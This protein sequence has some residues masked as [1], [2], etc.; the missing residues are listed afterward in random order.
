MSDQKT[1]RINAQS[2]KTELNSYKDKSYKCLFEYLWNSFDAG[3]TEIKF[4]YNIPTEGIGYVSNVKI[5]DNGKGWDFGV[6]SNTETFLASSKSEQNTNMKTLPKGKFGRGRYVFIW[7]A[8]KIEIKSGNSKIILHHSTKIEKEQIEKTINGTEIDFIGVYPKF[9]D[10]L[11]FE[12]KLHNELL[13][14]FGWYLAE[15]E[16]Y[17]ISINNV[18]LNFNDNIKSTKNYTKTDFPDKIKSQLNDD[19][20]AQIILWDNKPSEFSKFYFLNTKNV[21]IFKQ[22]TGL[23]KQGDDFWHSVYISSNIF[24]NLNG[25]DEDLETTQQSLH[26]GDKKIKKL[27]RQIISFLKTELSLLRKPYLIEQSEDL[28]DELKDDNI[29]PELTEFGIYDEKS[30]FD[31]IKTIYTITPSLFTGKG[32]SEKKFICATFAGL[33]STQDDDLIKIILEQLQELSEE[34]KKDLLDILNRSSLSNIVKT[35]KEIDHRL[36]VLEKLKILISEHEKETLEVK[37]LQ[38]IL[39]VNFWV[40]G[41]QFRLFSTTEGALKN[42]LYKYAKEIL[43]IDNPELTTQPNGEVD[44]FLTKT[45]VVGNVQKNIVVELK[46][47]SKKLTESK[48]YLQINNYRKSI[49]KQA[50]CN[51]EN[52]YWEFYLIGKNYD[53]GIAQLIENAKQHGEKEKG[54][55]F[56]LNGKVKIYVRKWSDILEVEWGTKMKY[57][58]EKLEIQAKNQE[59]TKPQEI[60]SEIIEKS[61]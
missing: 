56:N 25:L 15:N 54:L 58:K 31:L 30:Y 22:N 27:K 9:S 8:D 38:K 61:T 44:L 45:E 5:I 52:Q 47:A 43:E 13:L 20:N 41:E 12:E 39:D 46:R 7:I 2:I 51:G 24:K 16:K 34:E 48:D 1:L 57:L 3:A 28:L 19:F 50:L 37:H 23:N 49:L 59:Y 40:F 6:N 29:I 42:V 36:D 55:A 35:I 21:E 53:E 33:L 17:S 26:F 18:K 4:N 32:K 60:V 14:E 10:S 11:L